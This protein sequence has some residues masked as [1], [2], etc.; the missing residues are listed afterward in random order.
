MIKK[1]VRDEIRAG[2]DAAS[3]SKGKEGMRA[4]AVKAAL[5]ID[6]FWESSRDI[7]GPI[8]VVDMFSGCGGMSAGFQAVNALVP[9]FRLAMSMDIDPV[10]NRTY[11]ANFGLAPLQTDVA[12][13]AANPARAR[14]LIGKYRR[15]KD[16]PLVMIGCAPCQG[17]SSHRNALGEN[18]IRNSL[19]VS[20]ARVAAAVKPDMVICENVPELLTDR[21]WPFVET[22]GNILEKAGYVVKVD[23][24]DMAAFGVPQQRF[25]AVVIAMRKPFSLPIPLLGKQAYRTVRDAISGLPKLKAGARDLND[26]LHFT[27]QHRAST[28]STI[29]Q[30]PKNGGRLPEGAGPECLWRA[31]AKSGRA[32]YEDVYGRLWWDR[33]AITITAHAR[34]PASGRYVHPEQNRGLSVREAALLQSFP[35]GF[36]FEGTL[37]DCFRQIGNAVPPAFAASLAIHL[38]GELVGD[39][40]SDGREGITK[41][42]GPSFS[43]LIP[44]I[45]AGYRSIGSEA[46]V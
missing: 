1:H 46:V 45:K 42:V 22:A 24:H 5:G 32:V 8:D 18:D 30:V 28:I 25:R 35:K 39:G 2:L 9:A 14:D 26:P 4:L 3:P 10:A 15:G 34:N 31:A 13:L 7:S 21:H 11:E 6:S 37:D 20:F 19:F 40:T 44:A 17:F 36:R 27:V 38:L 23:V 41:P 43:R 12:K 33:P 16:A 29:R